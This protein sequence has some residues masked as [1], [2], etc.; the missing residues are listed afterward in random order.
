[1]RYYLY[2]NSTDRPQRRLIATF[3]GHAKREADST[4][5]TLQYLAQSAIITSR[6][7][8]CINSASAEN[9]AYYSS[10]T[11]DLEQELASPE[12]T[13]HPDC[14]V[15][16]TGATPTRRPISY[17]LGHHMKH[18]LRVYLAHNVKYGTVR[19]TVPDSGQ[20]GHMFL[21]GLRKV[22]PNAQIAS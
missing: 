15:D 7:G 18:G 1:M 19:G 12:P 6:E 22:W 21:N 4:L 16:T 11:Y 13:P 14:K 3:L 5:A 9:I 17:T 2:R 20:G 8:T 10:F